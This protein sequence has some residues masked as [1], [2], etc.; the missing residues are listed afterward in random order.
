MR[1][2]QGLLIAIALY[3]IA[4]TVLVLHTL[5][6]TNTGARLEFQ[7]IAKGVWSGHG[8]HAY[9]VI[10]DSDDWISV[11]SQ[12]QQIFIPQHPPPEIDFS[13]AA[14][15]AVF[16]GECRTTGYSIEVKEI[17]DTGLTIIVKVEKV[18]PGKNC[19]VGLAL[20]CPYHIIQTSK[21][22]KHVIFQTSERT[23]NCG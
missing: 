7:T 13:K 19:I 14:V 22:N 17:I 12:H 2:K 11:W 4:I 1:R 8:N 6:I 5:G 15:I 16:M 18:Y 23:V 21:I 3:V 10:Q 20:T 9:Y